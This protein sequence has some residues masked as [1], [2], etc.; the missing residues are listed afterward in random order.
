MATKEKIKDANSVLFPKVFNEDARLE[1]LVNQM[2]A[3][4][5]KSMRQMMLTAGYSEPYARHPAKVRNTIAF[6]AKT[7]TFIEQIRSA[8]QDAIKRMEVTVDDATYRDVAQS[9]KSLTH[10]DRLVTGESTEN[11]A[12]ITKFEVPDV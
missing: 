7:K 9:L 11:I 3:D 5:G 10:I 2:G 1:K 8:Q 4:T 6:K 12:Q